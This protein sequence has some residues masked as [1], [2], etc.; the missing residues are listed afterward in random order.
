MRYGLPSSARLIAVLAASFTVS[1]C[2]Q[3]ERPRTVSD[4]CLDARPISVN[5]APGA[6]VDDPGNQWDSDETVGEVLA[7][8]AVYERLCVAG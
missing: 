5:V 3:P 8:N 4:F 7:S 2:G 6:G 1:A